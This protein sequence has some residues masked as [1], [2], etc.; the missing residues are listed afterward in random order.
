MGMNAKASNARKATPLSEAIAAQIRAERAAA[1]LTK[2]DMIKRTRI[3]RG[4]YYD[5][6]A[7]TKPI[8][9]SQLAAVCEVLGISLTDFMLRADARMKA[10]PQADTRTA[11]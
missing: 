6:E 3:G 10:D 8:D 1:R 2:D 7:G 4:T 9:V 11:G 5:L